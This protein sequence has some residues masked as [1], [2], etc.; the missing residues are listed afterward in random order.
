V[1]VEGLT[2]S[3]KCGQQ[4]VKKLGSVSKR[5]RPLTTL[6]LTN[7]SVA[8]ADHRPLYVSR[9][10]SLKVLLQHRDLQVATDG[11]GLD[12]VGTSPHRVS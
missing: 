11:R 6:A 2:L 3:V 1:E 7:Q 4:A 10:S 12:D 9:A 5:K 8:L